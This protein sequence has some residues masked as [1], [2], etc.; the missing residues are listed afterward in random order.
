MTTEKKNNNFTLNINYL[1]Y[2]SKSICF[3]HTFVYHRSILYLMLLRFFKVERAV[4]EMIMI[5]FSIPD[6]NETIINNIFK[7]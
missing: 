1:L 4:I 5:E 6:Y 2:T 7:H 3:S